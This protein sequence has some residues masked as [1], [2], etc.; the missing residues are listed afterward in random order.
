M[1]VYDWEFEPLIVLNGQFGNLQD[2]VV[3][4]PWRRIATD[5]ERMAELYGKAQFQQPSPQNYTPYESLTKD[6]V[7]SWVE[8]SIGQEDMAKYDAQLASLIEY[9]RNPPFVSRRCPWVPEPEPVIVPEPIAGTEV[10]DALA[11]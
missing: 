5:G 3:A 8:G 1:I 9:Q 2:V 11:E 6:Q 10:K 4:A 7:A